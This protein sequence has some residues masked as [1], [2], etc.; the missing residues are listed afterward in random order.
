MNHAFLGLPIVFASLFNCN[1]QPP[2]ISVKSVYD[3]DTVTATTGEK[4]RLACIDTPEL[5]GVRKDTEPARA[6]RDYLRS[7]ILGR[8]VQIKRITSDRY[9]RTVAEIYHNGRN[10]NQ[11]MVEAG[12]AEIYDRYAYQCNWTKQL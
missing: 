10:V 12:H 3:G 9:G 4:I 5:R 2:T 8:D 7:L 6:A 11:H 1:Y